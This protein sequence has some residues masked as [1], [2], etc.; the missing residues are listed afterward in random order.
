M[1]TL[2]KDSLS[3]GSLSLEFS[4]VFLHTLGGKFLTFCIPLVTLLSA[5]FFRAMRR[6]CRARGV[7]GPG[8]LGAVVEVPSFQKRL[9]T[10]YWW[11]SSSFERLKK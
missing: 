9:L 5:R 8:V 3:L 6:C 1:Q 11:I 4:F 2:S 7:P 10:T